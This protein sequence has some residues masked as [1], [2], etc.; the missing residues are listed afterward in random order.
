MAGRIEFLTHITRD[1]LRMAPDARFVFGDNLQRRGMG[2]QA[3]EM[4]GEPNAIGIPTKK[5]PSLADHAFFADDDRY[6]VEAIESGLTEVRAALAEGRM[7][8]IPK[9]GIGTGLA[10]LRTRAPGLYRRLYYAIKA[11]AGGDIPWV[12]P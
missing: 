4:R 1:M 3:A 2:G 12:A 8:Y 6:A 7:V 11:M 10:S 5:A 9:D